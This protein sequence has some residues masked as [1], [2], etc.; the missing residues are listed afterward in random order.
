MIKF[1]NFTNNNGYG[2]F[3]DSFLE[4]AAFLARLHQDEPLPLA[5]PWGR[6]EWMF[7]L[8]YLD[9]QH[10]D[11]IGIWEDE[12]KIIALVTYE[13]VFGEAYYAIDPLYSDLKPVLANY[14]KTT[15]IHEGKFRILIPENDSEMKK[16]A[17]ELGLKATNGNEHMAC[18]EAG[19]PLEYQL[20]E[21]FEIISLA[22][23]KDIIKYHKV[24]WKGFNHGS[25]VPIN[26]SDLA[27]RRISLSGPHVD[28]FRNIAVVSP[29]GQFVSYCGTWYLENT[30]VALVEPVATDPE[31]RKLGLGKAAVLE[32]IKRC[33][34]VGAKYAFVGSN[35]NFYYR[36]GFYPLMT[37]SW[38]Q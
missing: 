14:A 38:W 2:D 26:E 6:W 24:L 25:D 34:A 11:K 10:L 8:C 31:Y 9:K 33:F 35:Q 19:F 4:V 37:Y 20:P 27:D 18:F 30:C 1:R 16:A 17:F 15:F 21:G 36:L 5:Y 28:L 29:D 32:A 3:G 22:E 13:S 7:S 23:E 12:D